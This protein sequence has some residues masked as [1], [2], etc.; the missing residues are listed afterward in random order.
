MKKSNKRL[1]LN[2]ESIRNLTGLELSAAYGGAV[3]NSSHP[4]PPPE[5]ALGPCTGTNPSAASVCA[6]QCPTECPI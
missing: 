3:I 2:S 6:T 1:P 5:G 4:K